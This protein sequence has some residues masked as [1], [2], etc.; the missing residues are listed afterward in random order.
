[1]S[2]LLEAGFDEM[3]FRLAQRSARH[4]NKRD[5]AKGRAKIITKS[6]GPFQAQS[7]GPGENL[8]HR[9]VFKNPGLMLKLLALAV[10]RLWSSG[11]SIHG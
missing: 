2:K 8:D 3:E 1:M 5:V 6:N 10:L 11:S 4:Q 9:Q 7:S